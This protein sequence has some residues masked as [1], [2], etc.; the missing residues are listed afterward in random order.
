MRETKHNIKKR[1]VFL[2]NHHIN[3]NKWR[4]KFSK[5]IQW[6]SGWHSNSKALNQFHRITRDTLYDEIPLGSLNQC[7]TRNSKY[8]GSE[9][10]H[11]NQGIWVLTPNKWRWL[12]PISLQ[13]FVQLECHMTLCGLVTPNKK[14]WMKHHDLLNM[15]SCKWQRHVRTSMQNC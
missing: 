14:N 10:P 8:M 13:I 3:T 2:W 15:W 9:C 11:P 4:T 5:Y 1:H 7:M 12:P 6:K